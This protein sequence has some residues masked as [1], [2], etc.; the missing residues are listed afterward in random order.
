MGE[1]IDY[2]IFHNLYACIEGNVSIEDVKLIFTEVI[3]GKAKLSSRQKILRQVIANGQIEFKELRS[4][5][6]EETQ[7]PVVVMV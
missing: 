6:N 3:T 2:V 4:Q 1:P 7:N 5:V